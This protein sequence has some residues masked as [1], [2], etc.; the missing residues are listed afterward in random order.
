M[1]LCYKILW[2]EDELKSIRRKKKLIEQYIEEEKGFEP[3]IE[4]IGTFSEFESE[5]GYENTKEYD[6]LLVDL[7][8]GNDDNKSEGNTIIRKIR[9]EKVYTEIIFYSSHYENLTQKIQEHFVEGIFTSNRDELDLKAKKIID[10]TIKKVQDVNNL[11]GLIMAEVADLEKIKERIILKA[12]QRL[13]DKYLEKYVLKKVK[14][15]GNSTKNKAERY[16]DQITTVTF[17]ELFRK[18]GFI[19][20]DKKRFA[21]GKVL[22]IFSINEPMSK[23]EF[24]KLFEEEVQKVRNKFAHIDH[25]DGAD[26]QGNKCLLVGDIPFTEE[27]CIQI[28]KNIK[29]YKDILLKIEEE[30][31]KQNA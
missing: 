27:K 1:T 3:C 9:D 4:L 31:D 28:R 8:L 15:S 20:L 23:D 21:V 18:V 16:L 19:D 29:K 7:D 24:L 5:V 6:L 13:S 12:S 25:C 11:R 10:I 17:D 2:I 22:E 30:I 26:S 14:N